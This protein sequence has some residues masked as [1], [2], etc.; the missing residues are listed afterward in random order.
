MSDHA[1]LEAPSFDFAEALDFP[2][3]IDAFPDL[4]FPSSF[5]GGPPVRQSIN[6]K[7]NYKVKVKKLN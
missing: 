7:V 3:P 1:G 6:Q 5:V 2:T 4:V